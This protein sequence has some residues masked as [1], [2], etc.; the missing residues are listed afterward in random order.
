METG[1]RPLGTRDWGDG[2]EEWLL[3]ESGGIFHGDENVLK[4]VLVLVIQ[5]CGCIRTTELCTFNGRVV[6]PI[7]M[8]VCSV[9]SLCDPMDRSRP[10]S[11]VHGIFQARILEWFAISFSRGSSQLRDRTHV[12]LVGRRVLYLWA[13]WEAWNLNTF[14]FFFD[15]LYFPIPIQRLMPQKSRIMSTWNTDR[16][17]LM[18]FSWDPMQ[19]SEL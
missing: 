16:G 19:N 14:A 3:G 7:S 2:N 9:M 12:S 18:S 1:S 5:A 11:S 10:G 8:H 4:S 13:T 15:V 17:G 6:W